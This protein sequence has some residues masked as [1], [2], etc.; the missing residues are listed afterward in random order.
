MKKFYLKVTRKNGNERTVTVYLDDITARLLIKSGDKKLLNA[1]LYEEYKTSRR[2]RQDEFWNRSL[3]EALENGCDYEDKH[4]YGDFSFD[5][6]ENENLQAA[7]K[8]LTTRQ[9]EILRLMY[10]EGRTQKEIADFYGITQ[11]SLS[12]AMDRI[13]ASLQRNYKNK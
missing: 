3:D 2:N 7:I 5:N 8:Q 1:Y 4:S 9:Q 6:F 13:Y 12:H 11:S 10:I